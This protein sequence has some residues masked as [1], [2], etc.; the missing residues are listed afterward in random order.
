MSVKEEDQYNIWLYPS[1]AIKNNP[2]S[3]I[4]NIYYHHHFIKKERFIKK[5]IFQNRVREKDSP[6]LDSRVNKTGNLS[7]I[8]YYFVLISQQPE[9]TMVMDH[10]A[11]VSGPVLGNNCYTSGL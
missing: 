11:Y 4:T 8:S 9:K 7:P 2:T 5:E 1:K 10:G 3:T 6:S